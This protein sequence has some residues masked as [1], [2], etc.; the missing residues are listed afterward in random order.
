MNKEHHIQELQKKIEQ[1]EKDPI[2]SWIG[3]VTKIVK[4]RKIE[5]KIRSLRK[6]D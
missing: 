3:R 1:I 2:K 5:K 6:K 4:I